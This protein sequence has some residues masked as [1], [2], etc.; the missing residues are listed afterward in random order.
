[1]RSSILKYAD[2]YVLNSCDCDRK[3]TIVSIILNLGPNSKIR[4]QKVV[5]NHMFKI[6]AKFQVSSSKT[7]GEDRFLVSK[8][9]ILR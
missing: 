1:M 6:T 3:Y 9:K 5:R 8:F 2:N 7:V 4:D